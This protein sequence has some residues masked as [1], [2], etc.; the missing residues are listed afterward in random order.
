MIKLRN[1]RKAALCAAFLLLT[2]DALAGMIGLSPLRVDFDAE[3]NSAVVQVQNVGEDTMSMQVEARD[4]QQA[5][6]GKDQYDSTDDVIALPPIFTI[7]PGETQ[8]VR[9][10]LLSGPSPDRELHHRLFFT[11]LP[12]PLTD[13]TSSQLRMRLIVSI[14][15]FTA[16]AAVESTTGLE[17]VET[18]VEEGRLRARFHN[19]GNTHIRVGSVAAMSASGQ[20]LS[21]RDT[22]VYLLPGATHDFWFEVWDTAIAQLVAET[23]TLGTSVHE[24]DTR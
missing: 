8:I 2:G 3:T 1:N 9:L 14:P 16:P 12:A 17:L 6:D 10:G 22:A 23:D 19:P 21:R 11:E 20:E 15:I 4:W 13:T 5:P 18:V 24:V 7:E